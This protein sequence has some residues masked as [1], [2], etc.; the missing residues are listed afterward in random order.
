MTGQQWSMPWS[1]RIV[2]L[3][4]IVGVCAPPLAG[5]DDTAVRLGNAFVEHV[6][7]LTE[8]SAE[9][10]E[11]VER[12]WRDRDAAEP[13]DAFVPDALAVIYPNFRAVLAA[14]DE[15]R[16]SEAARGAAAL[17]SGTDPFL[18]ATAAYYHARSLV[19]EGRLEE[20]QAA[21]RESTGGEPDALAMRT[22][23]APHLWYLR[24]FCEASN[25]E[26]EAANE[27]LGRVISLFP[28]APEAVAV[29]AR[30]LRLELER[31]E[32][33][34]LD[35]V[36]SLMTYAGA[37]LRVADGGTR[38]RDR[39]NEAIAKLDQMI[40]EEEQREKSGQ[41]SGGGQG[42]GGRQSRQ[43]ARP[44]RPREQSEAP[45]SAGD[46]GMDL[47]GAQRATPGEVWGKLPPAEREKI[48]Q[49]LRERFPSRYRQLVEQYYRS[50]ADGGAGR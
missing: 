26:F 47:R 43:A 39:Q 45:P 3:A 38:V 2:R 16:F 30:Q 15:G 34:T 23:Y 14:F 4:L 1:R 25:L 33:G 11:F 17:G 35:E 8:V 50:L 6:R 12:T 41:C 36:A 31:R 13:A 44:S 49:S 21:L 42:K 7:G 27:S 19:E 18:S 9:A 48:L 37:R 10:R 24:G 46:P 40:Q 28:S 20:A 5:A 29:G 22:P 32:I